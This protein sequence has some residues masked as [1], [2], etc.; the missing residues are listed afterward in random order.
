MGRS[1]AAN[2]HPAGAALIVYNRSQTVVEELTRGS[3]T[4]TRSPGAVAEAADILI[5]M[6]S[7]TPAVQAVL[8]GENGVIHHM[9]PGM[10]IIDLGTTAVTATRGF[11]AEFARHGADHVEAPVSG[12]RLGARS[13]TLSMMAAGARPIERARPILAVLGANITHVGG[14]GTGHIAQAASQISV[15]LTIGAVAEALTLAERA[16]ADPANVRRAPAGGFADSR[17]LKLATNA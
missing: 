4:P 13:A 17:C 9:R 14:V 8:P 6:V 3:M 16:D 5:T 11:A 10:L 15:G 7:D 2:L 1:M 12:G